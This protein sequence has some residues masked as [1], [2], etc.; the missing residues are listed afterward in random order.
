MIVPQ[1]WAE[2]RIQHRDQR[3][4][5]T[6]RRFGWSDTS[7]AEAEAHARDRAQ[8]ALDR[9]LSGAI[10]PRREPKVPYNGA[11]GVP[12]REEIVSRHGDVIITRNSYGARCLNTPNVFF[13]DIDLPQEQSCLLLLA[14]F[15]VVEAGCVIGSQYIWR[16]LVS[17]AIASGIA[18]V[19]SC[20]IAYW[21]SGL[22]MQAR[23]G[24]ENVV[25]DRLRKFLDRHPD[26]NLR[27]YRTPAGFRV[28]AMHQTFDPGDPAV[29]EAFRELGTDTIYVQ[30]C[31][32][33]QCFRARVSPKPWRI[34]IGQH[35]RPRRGAWPVPPDRLPQRT[36]WI[37]AY[38]VAARQFAACTFLESLGS[39]TIHPEARF[40]QELHD[41]L[42]QAT[43]H[44]P[45]A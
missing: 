3:R 12:I 36:Q 45:I 26:W 15:A 29:A 21:I 38:E 2:S 17:A 16:S 4:Q 43:G 8:A 13:A 40:V 19:L 35:I 14:V 37:D 44:L 20:G 6:L 22:I 18:A 7:Q 24:P 41:E 10:L 31:L 23:G 28:L 27:L 34:G 39:G 9:I 32:K 25:R 42:C 30:M 11:E 1:Y 33:Q 5:V